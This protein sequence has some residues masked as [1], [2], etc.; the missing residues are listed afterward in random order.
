M[1]A[2]RAGRYRALM[3]SPLAIGAMV[4]A[5]LSGAGEARAAEIKTAKVTAVYS[6]NFNGMSVGQ[7]SLTANLADHRYN[8]IGDAKISL[9][10]G[11]IFEWNGKTS[12]TGRVINRGPLPSAYSFGYTTSDKGEQINVKF[13]DNVVRE[14]AVNPP[15]RPSAARIPM[16][17]QHMQ[18][19][20]DPL[21][22]VLI[23]SNVGA[24]RTGA[25]VCNRHLPIF[26]GKAR[27]DLHLSYKR[28]K[29]VKTG[30]GYKGPA[31]VCKVKYIP[32]AGHRPGDEESGYAA[33]NEAIEV[34]MIPISQSGLFVPYY[35][36][37]P[38]PVG[39]AS[40]TAV[41]F[42]VNV[43]GFG[44]RARVEAEVE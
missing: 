35:I 31:Y 26:D 24:E 30:D 43:P 18:N 42:D 14:I 29:Q 12:S 23:L 7:F 40:L 21:S 10:A 33:K 6:I 34:W 36:Y 27:Y 32:I 17:R 19:V 20:V 41:R 28:T 25:E 39:A 16:T 15:P 38:T 11:L 37:I 22:A 1:S 8:L 3:F 2:V 44:R 13:S 9:L 5:G 4:C